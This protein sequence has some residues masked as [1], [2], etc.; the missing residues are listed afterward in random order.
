[1]V[2]SGSKRPI[3]GVNRPYLQIYSLKKIAGYFN[4]RCGRYFVEILPRDFVGSGNNRVS[5]QRAWLYAAFH[6]P[7]GRKSLPMS[8]V[9]IQEATIVKIKSQQRYDKSTVTRVANFANTQ[10]TKGK[11]TPIL[12]LMDGKCRQRLVHK[13]LGNTYYCRAQLSAKGML[14]KVD[15][16][17]S[18]SLLGREACYLRRFFTITG[19]HIKYK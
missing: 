19:T 6:K 1:M 9:S 10:D 17:V 5:A 15:D 11:V 16:A 12:E 8:R 2:F 13:R 4:T 14:R 18:Q 3:S 7:Q